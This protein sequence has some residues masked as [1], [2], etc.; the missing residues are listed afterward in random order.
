MYLRSSP[1]ATNTISLCRHHLRNLSRRSLRCS[2]NA[3]WPP[4]LQHMHPPSTKLLRPLPSLPETLVRRAPYYDHRNRG[5]P[6]TIRTGGQV[7]A[8]HLALLH[9][10]VHYLPRLLLDICR[11]VRP[12]SDV[13]ATVCDLRSSLA[14]L[15]AGVA[16]CVALTS[17]LG[18]RTRADVTGR[19]VLHLRVRLA[20]YESWSLL[21]ISRKPSPLHLTPSH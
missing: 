19:V 3:L 1:Q 18:I 7:S 16:A 13:R 5:R 11:T 2:R 9:Q 14:V 21:H 10:H 17:A 8:R 20:L 12:R 6:S 4:L 15:G